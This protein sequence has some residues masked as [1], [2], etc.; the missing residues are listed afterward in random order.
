MNAV[1]TMWSVLTIIL[2]LSAYMFYRQRWSTWNI[3]W[4]YFYKSLSIDQRYELP[5]N[6][7]R[8]K[9]IDSFKITFKQEYG[10][11]TIKLINDIDSKELYNMNNDNILDVTCS[12]GRIKR[13]EFRRILKKNNIY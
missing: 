6:F 13:K 4:R 3:L 8:T 5:N 10:H 7:S 9:C 1:D 12:K 11:G 2:L